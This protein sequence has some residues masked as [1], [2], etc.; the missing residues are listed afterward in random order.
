MSSFPAILTSLRKE[1]KLSQKVVAMDLNI[2]QALLSH[3]EKGVRECSLDLLITI[4]DYF[5]VSCDYLLG[6]TDARNRVVSTGSNIETMSGCVND[7]ML[8]VCGSGDKKLI[9]AVEKYLALSMYNLAYSLNMKSAKKDKIKLKAGLIFDVS[10]VMN[11]NQLYKIAKLSTDKVKTKDTSVSISTIIEHSEK[12]FNEAIDE[13]L[14]SVNL[15][16]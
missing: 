4:A 12:Y 13:F 8:S 14:K 6:C 7:I 16:K 5:G 3:Y 9:D 1:R 10:E 15:E 2:S 11:K